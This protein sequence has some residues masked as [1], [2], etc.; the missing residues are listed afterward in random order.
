MRMRRVA[1]ALLASF[2]LALGWTAVARGQGAPGLPIEPVKESGQSVTGAF[3]GWY[4]NADGSYTLL[5]G[6][7]NRNSK[8]TLDIPVGPNNRIDPGGPDLGQPTHFLPRRQWGVFTIV[9]PK[10]FAKNKLT[11]TI[12]AN[13]QT[14]AVPMHLDPLWIV[15]PYKD[16]ALGNMP[17]VLRLNA[18]GDSYTGPPK[19]FAAS[20]TATVG[21]PLTLNAWTTDDGIRAPEARRPVRLVSVAWS[22]FRGAGDVTFNS[23][24]PSVDEK[25]GES[26]TTASFSVPGEYILR[27]QVNDATGEGGG[28]FQCCWTN[29]HVKVTVK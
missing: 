18:K 5:V 8:Q 14:T 9:V 11:W 7:F 28:G 3:E 1:A 12:V 27:V 2:V 16:V 20:Y 13:G 19:G 21:A 6:Y 29:A 17:P 10:E 22:K 23:A 26:T 4:Q 24:A 15:A 25:T